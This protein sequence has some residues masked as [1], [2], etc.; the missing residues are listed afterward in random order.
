MHWYYPILYTETTY[1]I[2]HRRPDVIA[3]GKNNK[4]FRIVA[5]PGDTRNV[6][7]Q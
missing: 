7:S 5:V 6:E 3:H 1:D 4:K 2:Y